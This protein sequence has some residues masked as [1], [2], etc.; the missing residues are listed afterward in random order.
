MAEEL[1]DFINK[2]IIGNDFAGIQM[3]V[4]VFIYMDQAAYDIYPN[5]EDIGYF[6]GEFNRTYPLFHFY[7][8]GF[9][10]WRREVGE[11]V[12]DIFKR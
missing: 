7:S 2:T 12:G 3:K 11:E 1:K 10:R 5:Q 4:V 9:G 8:H 6:F